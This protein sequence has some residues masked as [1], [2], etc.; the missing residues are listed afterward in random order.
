[1]DIVRRDLGIPPTGLVE[2]LRA[3]ASVGIEQEIR[4]DKEHGDDVLVVPARLVRHAGTLTLRLPAG[5]TLL[6][7]VLARIR[8]APRRPDPA[9][10]AP[11]PPGTP[12][13]RGDARAVEL[14]GT[15]ESTKQ[16]HKSDVRRSSGYYS[17][18]RVRAAASPEWASARRAS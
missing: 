5:Y 4:P 11:N 18:N 8:A 2:R 7:E 17:R 12:L 14:P 10:P 1:M 16:D 9:V 13:T 15:P 3:I 6:E